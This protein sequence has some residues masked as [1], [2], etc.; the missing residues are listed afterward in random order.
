MES[1][2]DGYLEAQVGAEDRPAGSWYW[3]EVVG[4]T[5]TTSAGEQLGQVSDIFRTGGSEVFVVEG[6]R[7]EVLVPAVASVVAAVR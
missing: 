3:H 7:G 5:V 1:L 6:P 4:V 2:R